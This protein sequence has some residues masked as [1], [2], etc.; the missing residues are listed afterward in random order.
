MPNIIFNIPLYSKIGLLRICLL[1]AVWNLHSVVFTF[2][3]RQLVKVLVDFGIAIAYWHEYLIM[4]WRKQ[5]IYFKTTFLTDDAGQIRN[6]TTICRIPPSKPWK[7]RNGS[8][9]IPCKRGRSH[10][11]PHYL[12]YTL[13][14]QK[15]NAF[16]THFLRIYFAEN[17]RKASRT[18]H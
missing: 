8:E 6:R 5:F 7:F 10:A 4:T 1:S 3:S 13:F 12:R 9:F 2:V 11:T 18:T 16:K 17:S 15:H 14:I